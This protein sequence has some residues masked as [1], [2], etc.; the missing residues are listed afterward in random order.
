MSVI[1][2]GMPDGHVAIY[3]GPRDPAIEADP[4]ADL[5]RVLFHTR[6]DYVVVQRVETVNLT[7]PAGPYDA[8]GKMVHN[9]LAHGL[10]Y[11]PLIFGMVKNCRGVG[12]NGTVSPAHLTEGPV[13]FSGTV[14]LGSGQLIGNTYAFKMLQLGCNETHVTVTD[15]SVYGASFSTSYPGSYYNTFSY[16]LELEIWITK[17]ALPV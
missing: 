12:H 17:T 6:L 10:P 3:K 13:P 1:T 9:V 15:V 11:T 2:R 7:L 14:V 8:D 4:F 16:D 5:G